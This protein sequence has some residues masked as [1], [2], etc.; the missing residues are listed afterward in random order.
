MQKWNYNICHE[1][2]YGD[3]MKIAKIYDHDGNFLFILTGDDA[4]QRAENIC[5]S[6]TTEELEEVKNQ[7]MF[8]RSNMERLLQDLQSLLSESERNKKY[9]KQLV[10]AAYK[11]VR[12]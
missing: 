3:K 8:L 4:E 1:E 7:L 2:F 6:P 11:L 10:D 5:G 9:I 12:E